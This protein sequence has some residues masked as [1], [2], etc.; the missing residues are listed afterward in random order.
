M[1][2]FNPYLETRSVYVKWIRF[3]C[4]AHAQLAANPRP[5]LSMVLRILRSF[6]YYSAGPTMQSFRSIRL[7]CENALFCVYFICI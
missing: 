7:V 4:V 6:M 1:L 5:S 2:F 3:I